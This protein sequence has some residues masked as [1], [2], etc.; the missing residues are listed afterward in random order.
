MVPESS[1]SNSGLPKIGVHLTDVLI[2]LTFDLILMINCITFIRCND[3]N[4]FLDGQFWCFVVS[5]VYLF[6]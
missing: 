4:F 6:V 3:K 1:D 5:L 2:I